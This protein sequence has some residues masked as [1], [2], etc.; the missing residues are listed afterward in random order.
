M[1]YLFVSILIYVLCAGYITVSVFVFRDYEKRL[2]AKDSI[3]RDYDTIKDEI[4]TKQ[5]I[6][7][8]QNGLLEKASKAVTYKDYISIWKEI[9]E[10]QT[11]KTEA[12]K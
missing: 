3:I 7:E 11:K 4:K 12:P 2:D 8:T 6:I 5:Q 1:K 9:N 10:Y